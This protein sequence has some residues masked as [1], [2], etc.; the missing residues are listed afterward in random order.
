MVFFNVIFEKKKRLLRS[1]II[2]FLNK[3]HIPTSY[4]E[5]GILRSHSS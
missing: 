4:C 2:E 3:P 1:Q 5:V